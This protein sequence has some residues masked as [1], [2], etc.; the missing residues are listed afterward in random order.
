MENPF[1][2]ELKGQRGANVD[3]GRGQL[4]PADSGEWPN[5]SHA[6]DHP[7]FSACLAADVAEVQS[8]NAEHLDPSLTAACQRLD[9]YL[10]ATSCLKQQ[11]FVGLAY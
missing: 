1:T 3:G 8:Y 2:I 6:V 7:P 11:V 5:L 9:L 4:P 10:F